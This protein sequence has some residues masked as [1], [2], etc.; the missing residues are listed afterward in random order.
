M[1]IRDRYKEHVKTNLEDKKADEAKR[2][3]EDAAVDKAI[4]NA[5]MDICLLYTSRCV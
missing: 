2:A 1:C 4:E 5:Q 3:K